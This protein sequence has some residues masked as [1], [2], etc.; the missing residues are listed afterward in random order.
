MLNKK[1]V[2]SNKEMHHKTLNRMKKSNL[3]QIDMQNCTEIIFKI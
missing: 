2:E 1:P 3:L